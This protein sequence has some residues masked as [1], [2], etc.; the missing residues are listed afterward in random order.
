MKR[1]PLRIVMIGAGSAGFCRVLVQDILHF[2]AL[3][4]AHIVLMDVD[5]DR[6]NLVERVMA[7]FAEQQALSC[8]FSATTDLTE[9][10]TDARFAIS[11]IQ[12]GGLE[13]YKLD[14]N[15][16]LKYGV[17]Q[18]VGDTMNPGGL[19]RGLRHIPAFLD[20]L[21]V[22]ER[23]CPD[24]I[25]MNYANP[26]AISSWAKQKA[27]PAIQSVGLCHGVQHTTA[28]L[29]RWLEVPVEQVEVLTAGINHM[30]WFL[31]FAH[32]GRD[33]YPL[34]WQKVARGEQIEGE[35]YRFE[36]MKAAGY[37]MTESS[38]H[39]SEYLP[40]FRK[41][42][43][44]Q[45]LFGGPGFAGETGAYLKMCLNG[46]QQYTEDMANWASGRVP[47]PFERGAKSVEYAADIMNAVVTGVPFRFAGNVLNKGFIENLPHDC[48]VEVPVFADAQG[49]HGSHVGRLPEFCAALCLSNI[50]FQELA[51]KAGLEG[52]QEAAVQACMLD[53][54]TSAVLAPH[55]IRNMV[56]EL[57]AAQ[58]PW[59]PQFRGKTNPAPGARIG[60][61]PTGA[62]APARPQGISVNGQIGH[63][64][65]QGS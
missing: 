55:E 17:D 63:Y 15:I 54:L 30:A 45:A 2:E 9:A 35:A 31:K 38:G 34:I 41:R 27:F 23:V 64:D 60:R 3:R 21:A 28:R 12:V 33:L 39:L 62:T 49:L 48:C 26:M 25:F 4:D 51:V 5:A 16:P 6:L 52:D 10:L 1:Q 44:L 24:I 36:M 7:R 65:A 56:D 32:A 42:K 18:C 43:D 13:P 57:L 40:Y 47:I 59:L 14:I 29:C 11:M 61:I 20:M 22:M 8:T 46:A 19:F 53:P 37:Y 50:V 58:A